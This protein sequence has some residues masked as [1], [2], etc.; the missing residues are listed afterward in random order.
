VSAAWTQ[1]NVEVFWKA[2]WVGMY[3]KPTMEMQMQT[4]LASYAPLIAM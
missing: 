1:S 3:N 4:Y 2:H